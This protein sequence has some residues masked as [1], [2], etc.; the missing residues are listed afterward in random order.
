M[1][2]WQKVLISTL[3]TALMISKPVMAGWVDMEKGPGVAQWVE[4]SID[5][6]QNQQST[7]EEEPTA[8]GQETVEPAAEQ[9]TV[10]S[11]AEGEQEVAAEPAEEPQTN[12]TR[13]IDPAKPMVALTFDDGPQ[14]DV[15]NRI[16][17]CLAQY[18]GKAT[19][20]MVGDRV[21]SRAG[22]VKRMAA[23]GHELANHTYNHKYL[24]KVSAAEVQAQVR[25]CNDAIE[26]ASGVRP[27]L[28]RLPG[29]IH[30]ASIR[31]NVQMPMIDLC[32][33]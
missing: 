22:V 21:A 3:V 26:S 18:G 8:A 31:A 2:K 11:A 29:G 32:T 6:A 14:T 15:D 20:F 12:G 28:M 5:A 33:N 7:S 17:D 13:Y 1:K 24:N 10:E 25:Q 19:F 16:L 27:T 23:E 9:E 4:E 30:N